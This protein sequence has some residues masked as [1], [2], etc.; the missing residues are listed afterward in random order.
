MRLPKLLPKLFAVILYTICT[1]RISAADGTIT[2]NFNESIA[3]LQLF[4]G[5]GDPPN[6]NTDYTVRVVD[7]VARHQAPVGT[8]G[9]M[10]M[11]GFLDL[12]TGSYPIVG[13]LTVAW[14]FPRVDDLL[15]LGNNRTSATG[16]AVSGLWISGQPN[17]WGLTPNLNGL[18]GGFF[19]NQAGGARSVIRQ[20]TV[21]LASEPFTATTSVSYRLEKRDGML[22]LWA[23]YDG[24]AWHQVGS[25]VTI[26]LA[27][28]NNSLDVGA[29]HLRVIDNSGGAMD[30]AADDL[31]WTGPGIVTTTQLAT[32]SVT[33]G[34][35]GAVQ[36]AGD[37]PIGSQVTLTALPE[38]G[39]RLAAWT[40]TQDDQ[41]MSPTMTISLTGNVNIQAAFTPDSA[42]SLPVRIGGPYVD[43]AK[44][45]YL[46]ADGSIL[47]TGY[48][49]GT[50][51][52]DPGEGVVYRTAQGDPSDS[53]MGG[54]RIDIF[55]AR[56]SPVGRL[57]WVRTF[58]GQGPD[59]PHTV[60]TDA[61]GNILL[62]GY[63]SG[64]AD[65]DSSSASVE[66]NAGAYG[67]D[68][69]VAK[70][71]PDGT[72]LWVR[73][74]GDV[75]IDTLDEN[76]RD[77]ANDLAL[78][79]AG[80]V[81]ITGFFN[82]TIDMDQTDG[83][84]AEDTF[85]SSNNSRDIFVASYAPDGAFRWGFSLG[86][87]GQ[88]HGA[89]IR[90]ASDGSFW[91]AGL[92][93][94]AVDMDPQSGSS[95]LN[96]AGGW[97][98]FLAHYSANRSLL[99]A[100]R[101]GGTGTDQVRPGALALAADGRIM[102]AGS[103]QSTVVT[104]TNTLVSAG[105]DDAF[106]ASYQPN[107]SMGWVIPAVSGTRMDFI[108]RIG[109]DAASNAYV[110]GSFVGLAD[111]NPGTDAAL[112]TGLGTSG[113]SDTFVAKYTSTGAYVWS[114]AFGGNASGQSSLGL[115]TAVVVDPVGNIYAAGRFHGTGDL[116][117]G[118]SESVLSSAGSADAF[119]VRIDISLNS[120]LSQSHI[121]SYS[122][123]TNGSVSGTNPQT[124]NHGANSSA[125]TAVP[126][127]GYRFVQWSD[128]VTDNPRTD[129]SVQGNITVSASF[130]SLDIVSVV[131]AS[132]QMVSS[133]ATLSM[134][135]SSNPAP[136]SMAYQWQL[137]GVNISGA[138][139]TVTAAQA[140]DGSSIS[141]NLSTI[142]N[143]TKGKILTCVLTPSRSSIAYAAF[144]TS[145][146]AIA[147]TA[148]T[149]PMVSITPN[150]ANQTE[151]LIV[152]ATGST[153][154]DGDTV[155]YIY[156]W[157][158][159]GVDQ[160][161]SS[162]TLNSSF[163]NKSEIWE[164]TVTPNDGT[165]NGTATKVSIT[166][167]NITPT[168]SSVIP[169]S[170]NGITSDLIT[171]NVVAADADGSIVSYGYDFDNDGIIE[172]TTTKDS[173]THH[174]PKGANTVSVTVTDDS[175]STA[176][177]TSSGIINI[178]N[179][180][181]VVSA[182]ADFS[183]ATNVVVELLA[184]GSDVDTS[185]KLSY[186]WSPIP[187]NSVSLSGN[188]TKKASF[189]PKTS[190]TYVFQVTLSD[191]SLSTSDNVTVSIEDPFITL[192]DNN[193]AP[194]TDADVVTRILT[195]PTTASDL[196][197]AVNNV[198]DL[199]KFDLTPAQTDSVLANIASVTSVDS[200]ITI[201]ASQTSQLLAALDN[202]VKAGNK[203]ENDRLTSNQITSLSSSISSMLSLTTM[204]STQTAK[205][206]QVLDQV[207]EQ[208]GG[209]T[210]VMGNAQ[211]QDLGKVVKQLVAGLVT[212]AAVGTPVEID[213]TNIKIFV[214]AIDFSST[215]TEVTAGNA[216]KGFQI[217][218]PVGLSSNVMAV[219][220]SKVTVN[221]HKGETN[222][223]PIGDV[224]SFTLTN[225]ADSSGTTSLR[226]PVTITIPF[227][228]TQLVAGTT[229]IPMFFDETTKMWKTDGISG[230]NVD[231]TAGT[232]TFSVTHLTDFASFSAP[233]NTT[234]S[235]G[236]GGG[237][238]F[239]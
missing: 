8:A 166:I 223:E 122:A 180:A 162:A 39:Y 183:G 110:C 19:W 43:Y 156:S 38:S 119:I 83:Q 144:T 215:S 106:L 211:V 228:K 132:V 125:I 184:E 222:T 224:V 56:F 172:L 68:V 205:A 182:G 179:T 163:T 63:F 70:Y 221:P 145:G 1:L 22:S 109:L 207:I 208:Q 107:G 187:E 94:G 46:D 120:S 108:H 53:I 148:P 69:F 212:S 3:P 67:R 25:N 36:G 235:S 237:C 138:T 24:Q 203:L 80:N 55:L 105:L 147:N 141:L 76:G 171:I 128:G 7:G 73:G 35:G 59:M 217:K 153:D 31:S 200:S 192:D 78:D 150:P 168:I 220:L 202:I 104:E 13:D 233:T 185:D 181:P 37:F 139:G 137:N 115:A 131:Q 142:P 58:G 191:G 9:V 66:L 169:S 87:S 49:Q 149:A 48:F 93:S 194:I 155:T 116:T 231:N 229:S 226:K 5:T 14:T 206:A 89:A 177:A 102:I 71:N 124:V 214:Q 41:S 236:G 174:F 167:S 27:A 15:A 86:S 99:S 117:P 164:V 28:L 52:F 17:Q 21:N 81:I 4:N 152:S 186:I 75:E 154:F 23:Q 79:D 209:T 161:I 140:I 20:G 151:N 127:A 210:T 90:V 197:L 6:G 10:S 29:T 227:D 112:L 219:S 199:A 216:T 146:I 225:V 121:L 33:V 97:D 88:D 239:R 61:G 159:N 62:T 95:M 96:S 173:A 11:T 32:V 30:V 190:G 47:V 44:D 158:K 60:R 54:N 72:L 42:G 118:P 65:F 40:G 18:W 113:A 16:L 129:A 123:D 98:A 34:T 198:A 51:D 188:T 143:A 189:I 26:P 176:M 91:L 114:Y 160:L 178:S 103:F 2:A 232:I 157:T 213:N 230:I 195:N 218:L 82:G 111:A 238:L 193:L 64:Q 12:P 234:G 170:T 175:G 45:L 196:G 84:D 57:E 134:T 126:N 77:E 130:S 204:T 50:V 100:S 165:I 92:F 85:T 136:D 135:L 74:F 201:N 101:F 133:S